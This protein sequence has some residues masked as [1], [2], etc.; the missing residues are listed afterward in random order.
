MELPSATPRLS[1]TTALATLALVLLTGACSP[2][3]DSPNQV[4]VLGNDYVFQGPDTLPAGPT[5]IEFENQGEV[6]HEMILVRLT[7]GTTLDEVMAAAE[8]E[9]TDFS[10]YLEGGLGILIADAGQ[11]A[12]SRLHVD[13]V[14]G[15][16]YALICN[17]TDGPESVPHTQLGMRDSFY[18]TE[19]AD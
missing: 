7:E 5:V 8:S 19:A 17:L 1:G 6:R 4:T 12:D 3:Q 16:T 15:R 14:P 13:L 9:E 11:T 2:G 10:Q 18:V